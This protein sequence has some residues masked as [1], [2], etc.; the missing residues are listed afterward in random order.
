VIAQVLGAI[1]AAGILFLIASGKNG[2]SL[3]GGFRRERF[4]RYS[5]ITGSIY[6][7]R[8]FRLRG[9]NDVLF[10]DRHH[11]FDARE[12]SEGIRSARDRIGADADPSDLDPVT[13][14]SVNP[15]RS[16]GPALFAG[17]WAIQQLWLFWVAP[18]LGAMLAGFF[19][20]G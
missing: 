7:S 14:T 4:R 6:A 5:G 11:G 17:G 1:A 10:P 2:F 8:R 20:A 16:T 18:I 3:A 9:R 13:N 19:Y 15:A 12:S